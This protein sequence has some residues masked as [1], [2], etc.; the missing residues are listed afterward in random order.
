M[1]SFSQRNFF[2]NN[3]TN[4]GIERIINNKEKLV[5][6]IEASRK[7]MQSLE[8]GKTTLKN[9]F[10]SQSGKQNRRTELHTFIVRSE[11]I[12]ETYDRVIDLLIVYMAMKEISQFKLWKASNYYK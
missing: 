5:R 12:V 9:L 11:A 3:S 1:V 7:E 2:K 6:K 8:V 4:L 10:K